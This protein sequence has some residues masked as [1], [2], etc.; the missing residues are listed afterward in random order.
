MAMAHVLKYIHNQDALAASWLKTYPETMQMLSA[1]ADRIVLMQ[2]RFLEC[3]PEEHRKKVK[4][5]DVGL[6]RWS[7][8]LHPELVAI[9]GA[10]ADA[11]A[12]EGWKL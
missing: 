8:C 5:V 2:P 9:V 4:V 12:G 10:A 7:N 11:W 3:I 6:D 1:W